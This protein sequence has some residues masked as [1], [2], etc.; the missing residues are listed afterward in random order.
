MHQ[1]TSMAA[2][3]TVELYTGSSYYFLMSLQRLKP[4]DYFIYIYPLAFTCIVKIYLL[5]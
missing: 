4:C 1:A 3:C 5:V 2:N